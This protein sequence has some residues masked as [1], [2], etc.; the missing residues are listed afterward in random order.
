VAKRHTPYYSSMKYISPLS[1]L[2][3][4]NCSPSFDEELRVERVQNEKI[5]PIKTE[6]PLWTA[7]F[8]KEIFDGD[9]Y[10]PS[11]IYDHILG[12]LHKLSHK[13]IRKRT[14]EGFHPDNPP[15]SRGKFWRISGV[16]ARIW[17][18]EIPDSH[19]PLSRVFAG[20]LYTEEGLPVLFHLSEKP[21]VLELGEDVV[22]LDGLFLKQMRFRGAN[23]ETIIAPFFLAKSLRKL[24]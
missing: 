17:P 20:I 1:L 11:H 3:L 19:S 8:G 9:T 14:L 21:R 12:K 15:H 18:E 6:T 5:T 23:G 16:I 22:E 7:E 10:L 24:L 2:I 4:I 13:A